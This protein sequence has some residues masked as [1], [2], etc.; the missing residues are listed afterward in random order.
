MGRSKMSDSYV[1]ERDHRE[2]TKQ[3]DLDGDRA[4]RYVRLNKGKKHATEH[5]NASQ[6]GN[7]EE[8]RLLSR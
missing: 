3:P 6:W 8:L 5:Q 2:Q 4:G 7:W 1:A